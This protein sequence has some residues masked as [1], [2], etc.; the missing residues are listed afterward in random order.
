MQ[1]HACMD[2]VYHS[3]ISNFAHGASYVIYCDVAT[4]FIA[5]I[6]ERIK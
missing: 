6:C 2:V 4:L 1:I 3:T 5:P